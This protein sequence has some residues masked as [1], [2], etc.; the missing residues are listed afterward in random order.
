MAK[1]LIPMDPK[2]LAGP[3]GV[4]PAIMLLCTSFSLW[5][6]SLAGS[7]TTLNLD[8]RAGLNAEKARF[9]TSRSCCLVILKTVFDFTKILDST[10]L[11]IITPLIP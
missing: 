2:E 7:Q 4:I 3:A 9:P 1:V 5:L 6:H 8:K 11:Y 10:V